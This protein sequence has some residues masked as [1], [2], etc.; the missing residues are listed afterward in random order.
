MNLELIFP[1]QMM[2]VRKQG[3]GKASS[4]VIPL[5]RVDKVEDAHIRVEIGETEHY[6]KFANGFTFELTEDK[7]S[8]EASHFA[9]EMAESLNLQ[10]HEAKTGI[11]VNG[12]DVIWRFGEGD[13]LRTETMRFFI[14]ISAW[15]H[16]ARGNGARRLEEHHL[17]RHG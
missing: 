4:E 9:H 11:R 3:F 13:D 12:V 14:A 5:V 15:E 2:I 6:F 1:K 17:T 10:L 7:R 8:P 16:F